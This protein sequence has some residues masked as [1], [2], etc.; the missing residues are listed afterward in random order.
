MIIAAI[1]FGA[2]TLIGIMA[3]M[4]SDYNSDG[5]A[6]LS[7]IT[8]ILGVLFTLF[9]LNFSLGTK[10]LTGYIYSNEDQAGYTTG[11][12]RFSENAGTDEQPM[13]CT[14]SNSEAARRI[15]Q[16]SGSGEKVKVTVP[17]YF[18]WSNN[19]FACGTDK[20]TI[21]LAKGVK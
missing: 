18:Y 14:P 5:W 10:N 7:M 11:H 20:V 17:P 19:P 16:Y 21:E 8:G 4:N 1:I 12:I 3:A 13:F 6:V 2:M 15:K 9:A